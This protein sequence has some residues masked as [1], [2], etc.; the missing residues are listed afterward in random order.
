MFHVSSLVSSS[1]FFL[2]KALILLDLIFKYFD[3]SVAF[4]LFLEFYENQGLLISACK[5]SLF[6]VQLSYKPL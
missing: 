2:K 1:H 3:P 5:D 4:T 6:S